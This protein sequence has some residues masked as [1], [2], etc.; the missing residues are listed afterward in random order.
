MNNTIVYH[1]PVQQA[2]TNGLCKNHEEHKNPNKNYEDGTRKGLLSI[3]APNEKL[4]ATFVNQMVAS[5][6][7][8]PA[9]R[10]LRY[11]RGNARATRARQISI[12]LMH[13][14]LSFSLASIS[15]IYNKDRTTIGYACRVIEDL[16]DTPAFDDKI[17]ELEE[18][19][20]TVLKLAE[21]VPAQRG[22]E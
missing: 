4:L 18:T 11:D 5:A 19:V 7:E 22:T 1:T 12:Y 15:R 2:G 9:E 3:S 17:S 6:F 21:Y 10:L 13:T 8:L 16:R 20:K 14:A